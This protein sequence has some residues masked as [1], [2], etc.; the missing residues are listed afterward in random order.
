[1]H[2]CFTERDLVPQGF[3][4][5]PAGSESWR[6]IGKGGG[7]Q[8]RLKPRGDETWNLNGHEREERIFQSRR[9]QELKKAVGVTIQYSWGWEDTDQSRG[10]GNVLNTRVTNR[11]KFV[12]R[13]S[14]GGHPNPLLQGGTWGEEDIK[15]RDL[16]FRNFWREL[17]QVESCLRKAHLPAELG[18]D[19]TEGGIR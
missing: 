17:W 16:M 2:K 18:L 10:E 5:T 8:W 4:T 13:V 7:G 3:E 15:K 6:R 1:M 12:A 9:Q 19:W 11:P 14:T